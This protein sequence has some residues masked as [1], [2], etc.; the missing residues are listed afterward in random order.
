MKREST[1]IPGKSARFGKVLL[2]GSALAVFS[3]SGIAYGA[4]APAA[5]DQTMLKGDWGQIKLNLRYRFEHVEQD[6]LKTA[7]GDPMRLRLGYLSPNFAGFQAYGEFE[8]NIPIFANDYND[9]S[10]GKNEYSVIADPAEGELNQAWLSYNTI[11][12][13]V[14]KAGRQVIGLDNQRFIGPVA[15]RQM[16]QSFDSVNL[17][18]GSLG[19]LDVSASYIWNVRTILSADVNMNSP[20]LNIRYT[21]KD[22]GSLTGY[23]YWLDYDDSE[24]SSA[25]ANSSQTYGLRFTGKTG[26]A[27]NLKLLYTAEY[28]TQSD[29]QK[30]PTNY[31]A[32]YYHLIGGLMMPNNGSLVSKLTGKIGY[33]VQESDNGVSFKTPLGTNHA[34]GGWADLFLSTPADGLK[35]LYGMV[36]LN[37]AGVD[38][39]LIYHDFQADA[40]GSDY[41]TEY[42]LKLSKKFG[43]NYAVQAFYADYSADEYKT[44]TQKFWLQFVVNY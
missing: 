20:I 37:I 26:V 11:P 10:N 8:G 31:T 36:G 23:G 6:N 18:N 25:Y 32:G 21:F 34:F 42:D 24:S 13:T 9:K 14:I 2:F 16:E 43:E 1:M 40:G 19:A 15:W 39:N 35:D 5:K 44:D 4:E 22:V 33:E 12:D 38:L 3:V 29:Y 7:N 17:M 30:N 41:G 28:A 27:E